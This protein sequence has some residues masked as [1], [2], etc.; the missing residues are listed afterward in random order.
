MPLVFG[1]TAVFLFRGEA[2][3]VEWRGDF[4]DWG[5]SWLGHGERL[6]DTDIWRKTVQL[7]P[8]SRLDY[9]IV[10]DGKTW[11]LDPLNPHRQIGGYGAN[12]EARMPDW[13]P[14]EW[15]TRRPDTRR[16]TFT[17]D[18][19]IASERLGYTVNYRVY[20]PPGLD[21]SA[22]DLPTLYVTDGS[23]YWRDEMGSMVVILDNLYTAGRISPAVVV[24]I[25]PWDREANLNRRDKE[26]IP[27]AGG[28]CP[29]C[30][31][32]VK[33]LIP[34]I[35]RKYP[36]NRSA[37]G[38]AVL[39]TSLGGLHSTFMGLAHG[40]LFGA[41]LIQSPSFWPAR[42][43]I[44][45]LATTDSYPAKVFLDIGLYERWYL[46]DAKKVAKRLREL[47]VELKYLELPDGHSWGHWR[48]VLDDA[49]IFLYGK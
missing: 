16:G 32:V 25:D 38:R 49:L 5:E 40:D 14:S 15:V 29:F 18:I 19:S 48:A 9:K 27:A 31:F 10:L 7:L 24:F 44:D 36:T 33:E 39:G 3:K 37:S 41:V 23:D 17:G 6:G 30:D 26:L 43:V 1:N 42:W 11:L 8:G 22:T 45:Q 21:A 46:K 34:T 20:T 2:E 35:D 28:E 47:G 13:V 12:S 4:S